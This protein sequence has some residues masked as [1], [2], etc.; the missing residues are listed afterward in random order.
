MQHNVYLQGDLGDR[1][2]HKFSVYAD[3][4]QDI[5]KC[6]DANRPEFKNYLVEC[7]EN[8]IGF[9]INHQEQDL[10]E[11]DL[12]MPLKEG[13]IT[14]S[15]VPAGSKSG[16]GKIIGAALLFFVVGPYAANLAAG[17]TVAGTITGVGGSVQAGTFMGMTAATITSVTTAM[18]AN[19]A[20]T[21]VQ[22]LMAPDPA[23]DADSPENYLFNGSAQ[24]ISKGDPVPVLYGELRVPGRP[25]SIDIINGVYLNPQS[26][27]EADGAMSPQ[28]IDFKD[29]IA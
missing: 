16:M 27:I 10:L 12:L 24:N 7:I 20:L 2:G 5:L 4:C 15:I 19:L 25:I 18:A 13:D 17:N 3:S 6:I 14:I 28:Q 22:Q 1:F 11:D 29:L 23:T 8:D 9:N 21:G 26:I